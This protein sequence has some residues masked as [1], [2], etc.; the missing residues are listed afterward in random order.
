MLWSNS[1]RAPQILS[2]CA[3]TPEALRRELVLR[4]NKPPQREAPVPQ[5]DSSPALQQE[6]ARGQQQRPATAK[7]NNWMKGELP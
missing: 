7:T 1:A 2:P 3:A 4:N 6:E 5:L